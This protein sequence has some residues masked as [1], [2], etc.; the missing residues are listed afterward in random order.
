MKS[1]TLDELQIEEMR[2]E[3]LGNISDSSQDDIFK[4]KLRM[5]VLVL[6]KKIG[7]KYLSNLNKLK[8]L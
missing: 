7:Q 8:T 1:K 3:L 4:L 6:Q 2:L 5:M